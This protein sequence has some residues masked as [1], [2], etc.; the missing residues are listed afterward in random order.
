V[1]AFK[2]YSFVTLEQHC[3][4]KDF[5]DFVILFSVLPLFAPLL[6]DSH[7]KSSTEMQ[8]G[9]TIA[10][11]SESLETIRWLFPLMALLAIRISAWKLA[12]ITGAAQYKLKFEMKLKS[13]LHSYTSFLFYYG[14]FL[15]YNI[16]M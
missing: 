4:S 13:R 11:K 8:V 6:N 15:S 3:K 7:L 12:T 14:L 1:I 10:R 16:I 2:A 5:N 9:P